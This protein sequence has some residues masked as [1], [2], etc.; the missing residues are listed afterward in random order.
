[1]FLIFRSLLILDLRCR[2]LIVE[3]IIL[4]IKKSFI[5][6]F[7]FQGTTHQFLIRCMIWTWKSLRDGSNHSWIIFSRTQQHVLRAIWT[8]CSFDC[9]CSHQWAEA[10]LS[11]DHYISRFFF[12]GS[13]SHL[14]SHTVASIVL[15]AVLVLTVVFGMGTGVTPKRIATGSF[16]LL[17]LVLS[18][19]T[20]TTRQ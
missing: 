17:Q 16:L 13:G 7:D 6:V 5:S 11:Y 18:A 15:S 9:F 8:D 19:L 2:F 14:S 4:L 12:F 20:L 10:F 3:Y 1:M